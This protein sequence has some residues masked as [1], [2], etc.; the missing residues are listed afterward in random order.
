MNLFELFVIAI[1]VSMDAFAV[2][3]CKG[4]SMKKVTPRNAIIV[5]LYFGIFQAVMP[6]IGYFLGIQFRDAITSIDHW[7]AFILLG[8]IGLTM[9]NESRNSSCD[10]SY[11]KDDGTDDSL[12][13]KKM[14]VLAIATSIDAL[15][16]G[17]TFAFL[18]V[19]IVP[20]VSFIGIVT[21]TLS[22]FAVWVGSVFGSFF[23]AKAEL[24]GGLILILMGLKILLEHTGVLG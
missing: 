22:M 18:K 8:I 9:I 23:K 19:S 11:T 20:A 16:V 6:L 2:A 7:I 10:V 4:L 24:A 13:F 15:A 21:F 17:V 12:S 1:G 14:S 3:I 5:G